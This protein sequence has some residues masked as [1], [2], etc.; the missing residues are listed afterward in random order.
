MSVDEDNLTRAGAEQRDRLRALYQLALELTEL[1]DLQT[2]PS[3]FLVVNPRYHPAEAA[4][5]LTRAWQL[6]K[7]IARLLCK[8]WA[9]HI[10][11]IYIYCASVS[12]KGFRSVSELE[13]YLRERQ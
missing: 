10:V 2:C 5:V 7:C 8:S 1:R 6:K 9:F 4:K 13:I 3:Q 11:C 12:N